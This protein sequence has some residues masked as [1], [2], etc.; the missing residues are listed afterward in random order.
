MEF[1]AADVP[2]AKDRDSVDKQNGGMPRN[3]YV[4]ECIRIVGHLS[5][6]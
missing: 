5:F 3:L 2:W 4:N 1:Y 6:S